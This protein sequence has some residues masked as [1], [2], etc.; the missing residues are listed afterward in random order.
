MDMTKIMGKRISPG[1]SLNDQSMRNLMFGNFMEPD[2]D[3]KIYDE[4]E[5]FKKLET[6][7][8][9][10][11]NEYNRSVDCPID[12]IVFKYTIEHISR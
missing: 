12:I 2:A 11:L 4:I 1:A 9:Y 5:N 8:F 3:P 7:V 10:Y 6:I